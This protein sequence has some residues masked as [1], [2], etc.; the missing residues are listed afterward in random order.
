MDNGKNVQDVTENVKDFEEDI[1]DIDVPSACGCTDNLDDKEDKLETEKVTSNTITLHNL[2][3][4][5]PIQNF[6][7]NT[8]SRRKQILLVMV[9]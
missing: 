3:N 4:L 6:S 7:L 1:A 5:L 8:T 9:T 2:D